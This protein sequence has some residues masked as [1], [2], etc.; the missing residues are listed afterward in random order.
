MCNYNRSLFIFSLYLSSVRFSPSSSHS[1][2]GVASNYFQFVCQTKVLRW[3]APIT[4]E[5]NPIPILAFIGEAKRSFSVLARRRMAVASLHLPANFDYETFPWVLKT[6]M[7]FPISKLEYSITCTLR[8]ADQPRL[9]P[10]SRTIPSDNT[11]THIISNLSHENAWWCSTDMKILNV[12]FRDF[13]E[14]QICR[15]E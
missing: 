3:M 10:S 1:R 14:Q 13:V 11:Q 7:G 6:S 4:L 15:C 5:E 9:L 8:I 12:H 2:R